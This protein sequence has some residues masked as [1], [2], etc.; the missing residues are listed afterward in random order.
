[1]TITPT[2][3]DTQEQARLDNEAGFFV[4]VP[5]SCSPSEGAARSWSMLQIM[6]HGVAA[7]GW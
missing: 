4:S 7:T 2:H 5:L 6:S 3:D 1:M